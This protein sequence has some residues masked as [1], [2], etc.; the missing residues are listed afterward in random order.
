MSRVINVRLLEAG[1][2][3]A[4]ADGAT[5]EVVSNP[6]DGVWVVCRY[7]ASPTDASRVGTEAMIFAQ[8]VVGLLD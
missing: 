7:V 3:I 6:R 8:E 2:R 4:L 5:A 1:M